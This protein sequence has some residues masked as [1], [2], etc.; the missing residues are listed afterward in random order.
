MRW[1]AAAPPSGTARWTR[2]VAG[3]SGRGAWPRPMRRLRCRWAGCCC[4]RAIRRRRRGCCGRSPTPMICARPGA[5]WRCAPC[6]RARGR[7]LRCRW[8]RCCRA[9]RP[10]TRWRCWPGWWWRGPACRAGA[11][12][13]AMAGYGRRS[14]RRC[15]LP[16][17]AWRSAATRR[18]RRCRRAGVPGRCSPWSVGMCRCS[19]ARSTSWRS[20][21]WRGWSKAGTAAWRD[22]RGIPPT[23]TASRTCWCTVPTASPGRC[24]PPTSR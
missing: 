3:W 4:A 12:C 15:G 21:G 5:A 6:S 16:W 18:W 11:A 23:R 24:A 10:T 20:P 2:R 13:A 1:S 19:A 7:R 8:A 14:R 17:T 22:G 9:M